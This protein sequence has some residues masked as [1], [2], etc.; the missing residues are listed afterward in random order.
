MLLINVDYTKNKNFKDNYSKNS[1]NI[2]NKT[3]NKKL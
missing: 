2:K 1:N 3:N